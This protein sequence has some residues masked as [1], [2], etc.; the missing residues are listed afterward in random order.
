MTSFTLSFTLNTTDVPVFRTVQSAALQL[1][2]I[3]RFLNCDIL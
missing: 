1:A 3:L 2:P